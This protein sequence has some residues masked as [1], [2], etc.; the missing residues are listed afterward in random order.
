MAFS[1]TS[2]AIVEFVGAKEVGVPRVLDRWTCKCRHM[3]LVQ[4]TALTE[5]KAWVGGVL[6]ALDAAL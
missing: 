1:I 2:P 6:V 3:N 4:I 5:V